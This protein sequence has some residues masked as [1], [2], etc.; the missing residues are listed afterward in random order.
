MSADSGDPGND[1]RIMQDNYRR[2]LQKQAEEDRARKQA[3]RE[4]ERE[5]SSPAYHKLLSR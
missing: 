4:R 5:V 2:E 3:E 1:R